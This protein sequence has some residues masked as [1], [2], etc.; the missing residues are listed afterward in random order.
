MSYYDIDDIIADS[1]KIPCQFNITVPGLGYLEGN[2][3]KSIKQNTKIELPFW[4][5]EILAISTILNNDES[6]INL[7]DPDFISTK[8]INAIKSDSNSIDL[9]KIIS[10]YYV[11]IEKWCKLFNDVELIENS[12]HLLKQRSFEINNF[13]NNVNKSVGS[14]FIY[15]LD[16]FEKKL[17]KD[18]CESNKLMKKW[19]K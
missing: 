14:D 13:A 3:G 17:Y 5:A 4:L 7:I 19:L 1:Q 11:S 10:H 16:E 8:I 12:M 15:T 2:P 9:H 6:F 18:S